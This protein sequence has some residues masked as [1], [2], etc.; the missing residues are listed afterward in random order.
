MISQKVFEELINK[1]WMMEAKYDNHRDRIVGHLI[2]MGASDEEAALRT[3]ELKLFETLE[4]DDTTSVSFLEDLLDSDP[5]GFWQLLSHPSLSDDPENG[6]EMPFALLYLELQDPASADI[7]WALPWVQDGVTGPEIHSVKYLQEL[8]LG[9]QQVFQAILKK[10][11]DWLPPLTGLDTEPLRLMGSMSATDE[12]AVLQII[13]MPFL[14][15]IEPDDHESL[16]ILDKL[17]ASD[18]VRFQDVV[19]HLTLLGGTSNDVAIFLFMESLRKKDPEAATAIETLPWVQDVIGKS[20]YR[21]PFIPHQGTMVFNIKKRVIS[22]ID[23][24]SRY[25]RLFMATI[26]KSWIQD[27]LTDQEISIMIYIYR[28]ARDYDEATA[29]Q[30]IKMPFLD[31]VEGGERATMIILADFILKQKGLLWL[32][33]HPSLTGGITDDQGAMVGL[34]HL[35][36]EDPEAAATIRALPWVL[37]GL[38]ESEQNPI[39]VLRELARESPNVFKTL[40]N[41]PWLQ[42]GLN[43]DE[44]GVVGHLTSMSGKSS[45]RRDEASALQIIAMPFLETI[46]RTDVSAM[47]SLSRLFRKS[48]RGYFYQ[49]LS[50]PTLR[51]GITDGHTVIVAALHQAVVFRPELL[52][53]L[54]DPE[55]VTAKK[56]VIQLPHSGDVAL[57]VIHI[58][59]GNYRTMD[60]LEEMVRAQEGFMAL[61][62]P[63][64]YVGLLIADVN[65]FGGSGGPDG[66]PTIDPGGEENRYLIAHELAHTYWYFSTRWI[67][68][69]GAEI[70]TSVS[71]DT[72]LSLNECSL[73]DNLSEL[74]R[75]Y[76]EHAERGLSEDIIYNSACAYTLGRGLFLDLYD[77][78]GD[79]AFR[80]GFAKLYLMMRDGELDDECYDLEYGFCYVKA[81]FVTT[82]PPESA[83]IAEPI[84]ERHYY[85]PR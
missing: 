81:A 28:I 33:S 14:E 63:T 59:H 35:E 69:G 10:E 51:D 57:G 56:R 7:L 40:T 9:Y 46:D 76:L 68:E 45:T 6:Q 55:K 70:M 13:E 38:A 64:S 73:A 60:I 50:H 5:D 65:E 61:P 66:R 20:E 30:I 19:S 4:S 52:D 80:E 48:D 41:M 34:W 49:V 24:A 22:L 29:L 11:I 77:S 27:D 58:G 21:T 1:P 36:W 39:L 32:L 8:A 42:D 47:Q 17:A 26:G 83:A 82:A 23:M 12:S 43:S 67:A 85:G 18:P 72:L 71:A 3:L 84:I 53:V 31:S 37:D 16:R 15:T 78:L 44:A 54:L 79:A 75:L 25:P 2:G 74:D 62:F